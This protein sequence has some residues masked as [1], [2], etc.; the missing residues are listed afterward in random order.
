MIFMVLRATVN[1][2]IK[3]MDKKL[4]NLSNLIYN[5]VLIVLIDESQARASGSSTAVLL[6]SD[7]D[8]DD[9]SCMYK[10]LEVVKVESACGASEP[11]AGWNEV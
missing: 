1:K 9:C 10:Y 11:S 3:D 7:E 5:L 4:T 2:S 8:I 6:P